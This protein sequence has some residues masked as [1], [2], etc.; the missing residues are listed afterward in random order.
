[1]YNSQVRL[2]RIPP[3]TSYGDLPK[4]L[5]RCS[6][7]VAPYA[8]LCPHELT[9]RRKAHAACHCGGLACGDIRLNHPGVV[10]DDL[11]PGGPGPVCARIDVSVYLLP[12]LLSSLSDCCF[13]RFDCVLYQAVLRPSLCLADTCTGSSSVQVAQH[14]P[15]Q[16]GNLA[17]VAGGC[18]ELWHDTSR[19]S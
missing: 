19:L 5:T 14:V 17:C 7:P 6:L 11:A 3:H 2:A 16:H 4:C 13:W 12:S 15:K 8:R 1:V 10:R 18:G 9:R